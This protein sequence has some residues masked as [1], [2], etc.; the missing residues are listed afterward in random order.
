MK[1]GRDQSRRGGP[2]RH[3]YTGTTRGGVIHPLPTY[4]GGERQ[5]LMPRG[6]GHSEDDDDTDDDGWRLSIVSLFWFGLG[7]LANFGP[8]RFC[9]LG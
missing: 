2:K 6:V 3:A 4:K 1:G 9:T 5:S 8:M 7:W